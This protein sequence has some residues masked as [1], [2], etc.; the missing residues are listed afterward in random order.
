MHV[1][2]QNVCKC[3]C[4][5]V[6]HV[7]LSHPE[8]FGTNIVLANTLMREYVCRVLPLEGCVVCETVV[9]IEQL[10][11]GQVWFIVLVLV[12]YVSVL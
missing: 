2:L 1:L 3:T 9:V 7:A 10:C 8:I 11:Y 12:S 6:C 4:N 5:C